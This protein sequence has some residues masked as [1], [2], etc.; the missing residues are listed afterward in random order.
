[1]HEMEI[2]VRTELDIPVEYRWQVFGRYERFDVKS[3]RERGLYNAQ[4]HGSRI[5]EGLDGLGTLFQHPPANPSQ[6]ANFI[7]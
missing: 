6:N 5:G 2:V 4:Q 7:K 3:E 1:M